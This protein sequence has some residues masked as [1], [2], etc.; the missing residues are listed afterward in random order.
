MRLLPVIL[1][2][3][4]LFAAGCVTSRGFSKRGQKLEQAGMF[5]EAAGMFFT[6]LQKNRSNVDAQIGMR[7]TGQLV[8]NQRLQEFVQMKTA[9]QQPE[10]IQAWRVAT[11]YKDRIKSVGVTLNIPEFYLN[12]YQDLKADYTNRLYDEG[13]ALMDQGRYQDAEAKFNKIANLDPT[14]EDA[15]DL[16]AI[17]FAEPLYKDAMIAFNNERYREAYNLMN[18]VN[19]RIPGYK[20]ATDIMRRSL[21][22]GTLTI[23]LLSFE[24]ATSTHGLD[25]RMDA[26]ALE[27]MTTVNDPFMRVVDR[28]NMELILE[29]Q[30]LGLS[31]I[32]SEETAASVG[33]LLGAQALLTGTVL[34]YSQQ[35][36]TVQA[37]ARDAYQQYRVK[38]VSPEGKEYFETRYNKVSFTERTLE[39][40][41]TVSIQYRVTSLSTGEILLSR[42]VDKQLGDVAHWAEYS[43]GSPEN[44][45]PARGNNV[46]LNRR[47]RQEMFALFNGRRTPKAIDDL[48]NDVF[49]VVTQDMKSEIAQML[50]QI[51]Q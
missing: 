32:F 5:E 9:D 16:A 1:S 26:Y 41:V 38:L 48:T 25:A 44:L 12:D 51:V 2:L 37:F 50:Q 36:G 46:S 39:N 14:N 42:I 43:G 23:A 29:E 6:A 30:K 45:F 35:P 4:I 27:A 18:Q 47:D 15:S 40:R 49:Q 28:K 17:A 7:N 11:S 33:Q 21:E 22:S 20:D 19:Q 8:L 3:L 31:G 10:A 34:S 24:N 13:I